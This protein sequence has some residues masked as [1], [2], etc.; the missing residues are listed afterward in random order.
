MTFRDDNSISGLGYLALTANEPSYT[1][2]EISTQFPQYAKELTE[3]TALLPKDAHVSWTRQA[4][5][6]TAT[7]KDDAR[8]E[9]ATSKHAGTALLAAAL[10][11]Q[12]IVYAET[13]G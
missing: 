2:E 11:W 4:S 10:K 9:K 13:Q 3:L 7:I 5:C 8:E 6:F 1:T 12:G